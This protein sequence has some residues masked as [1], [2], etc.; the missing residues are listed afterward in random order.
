MWSADVPRRVYEY[1]TL[2]MLAAT[3]EPRPWPR[4][5]NVVVLLGGR[6]APWPVRQAFRTSPPEEPFRGVRFRLE[7]VYQRS[8]AEL[9]G[10]GLLGRLFVPLAADAEPRTVERAARWLVRHARSRWELADLGATMA[11]LAEADGRE[12]G[13]GPVVLSVLDSDLVMQSSIYTMGKAEG[14]R[15]GEAKGKAEGLRAAIAMLCEVLDIELSAAR[16]A[17]LARL[18]APELDALLEALRTQRCWPR[19][20]R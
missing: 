18:S 8:V 13:L 9:E 10:W 15:E 16:R 19:S 6:Q 11:V 17:R 5:Q 14:L 12:R 7:A 4:L 1:N 20:A 2:S 3:A